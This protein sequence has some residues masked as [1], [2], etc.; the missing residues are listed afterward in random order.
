MDQISYYVYLVRLQSS[1]GQHFLSQ[2]SG[3][4]PKLTYVSHSPLVIPSNFFQNI[5][6]AEN[7]FS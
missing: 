1:V 2:T 6:K 4:V 5:D 3:N 7:N